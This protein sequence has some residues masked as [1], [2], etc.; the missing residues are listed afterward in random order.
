MPTSSSFLL[1]IVT[2][3]FLDMTVFRG[4]PP[5]F[6][7]TLKYQ[8]HPFQMSGFLWYSSKW[9]CRFGHF[10]QY[11]SGLEVLAC[12]FDTDI[13]YVTAMLQ[14]HL[15][16]NHEVQLR[17]LLGDVATFWVYSSGW[18][19]LLVDKGFPSY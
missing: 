14:L 12:S 9:A 1:C 5:L 3:F 17:R 4:T 16:L 13:N 19:R 2:R 8:L 7:I 10:L 11:I 6:S 15:S 18:S